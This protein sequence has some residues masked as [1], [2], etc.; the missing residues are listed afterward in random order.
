VTGFLIVLAVLAVI[1]GL[2]F[3]GWVAVKFIEAITREVMK[4]LWK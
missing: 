1:G 2:A 4:G 3:A